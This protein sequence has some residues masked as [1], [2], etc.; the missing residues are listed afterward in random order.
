M[1]RALYFVAC[2][3]APV[4]LGPLG[5]MA[6]RKRAC[7]ALLAVVV[8]GC[9]HAA[10]PNE[11]R[12]IIAAR[13]AT[14]LYPLP[15]TAVEVRCTGA[16]DAASQRTDAH[17]YLR[18]RLPRNAQCA[19]TRIVERRSVRS[20]ICHDRTGSYRCSAVAVGFHSSRSAIR[21]NN[22]RQPCS[23]FHTDT[24]EM[25]PN[26]ALHRTCPRNLLAPEC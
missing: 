10:A 11:T 3:S 24:L 5:V 2:G 18:L 16:V 15:D 12:L 13:D 23:V 19:L 7:A 6:K 9:S 21:A 14:E 8:A 26:R 22:T 25:T 4:S 1:S 20:G 17:G